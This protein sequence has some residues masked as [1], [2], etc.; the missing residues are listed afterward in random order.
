MKCVR[1]S[2]FVARALRAN[3]L[4][5]WHCTLQGWR[6]VSLYI[7]RIMRYMS[8]TVANPPLSYWVS[9]LP[10]PPLER[11]VLGERHIMVQRRRETSRCSAR[12]Q[13]TVEA[14]G[15]SGGIHGATAERDRT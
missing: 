6:L 10:M 8:V 5:A 2:A 14:R 1:F 4:L 15:Y 12:K 3:R 11:Q 9:S 7:K 13:G